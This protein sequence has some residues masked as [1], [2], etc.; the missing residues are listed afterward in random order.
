MPDNTNPDGTPIT[1]DTGVTITINAGTD[2]NALLW[3]AVFVGAIWFYG[4]K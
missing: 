3:L 1:D 2:W 4:K